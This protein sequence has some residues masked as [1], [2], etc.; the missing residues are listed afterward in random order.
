[1]TSEAQRS[2]LCLPPAPRV[3][4]WQSQLGGTA[5]CLD[6][7]RQ[8]QCGTEPGIVMVVWLPGGLRTGRGCSAE[9]TDVSAERMRRSLP[10][11]VFR[12]A[13]YWYLSGKCEPVF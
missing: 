9:N 11:S 13:L 12:A 2:L 6:V 4:L 3:G 5:S 7:C 1:M 10:S 8:V